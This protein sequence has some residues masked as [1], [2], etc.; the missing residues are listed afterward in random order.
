MS[1]RPPSTPVGETLV[2][3]TAYEVDPASTDHT[4][5]NPLLAPEKVHVSYQRR[6][7]IP[8]VSQRGGE[9]RRS[10]SGTG[11]TSGGYLSSLLGVSAL[12]VEVPF[13][14]IIT[15]RFCNHLRLIIADFMAV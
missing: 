3:S 10:E 11:M 7:P 2:D 6:N 5:A 8:D 12:E 15:L 9:V 13:N 4:C 14:P 1:S